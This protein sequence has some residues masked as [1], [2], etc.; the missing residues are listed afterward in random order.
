[1]SAT[2]NRKCLCILLTLCLALALLPGTVLAADGISV[3]VNGKAVAWTDAEPFIDAN[4]RTL[5]PLR[6]VADAMQL[7]V[8][9]KGA[10]REAVFSGGGKSITFTIDS[11][12]A[13]TSEGGTVPMDTAAVIVNDRTYA[14]VRYLAEYFGYAVGWDAATRTV[15]LVK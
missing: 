12:A 11:A 7:D 3:T 2:K 8:E 5:V 13:T 1:M 9:W 14:P 6:A 4:D 15:S 10:S